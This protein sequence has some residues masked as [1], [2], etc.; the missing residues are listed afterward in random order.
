VQ[1]QV[2]GTVQAEQIEKLTETDNESLDNLMEAFS[3]SVPIKKDDI[4]TGAS[5]VNGRKKSKQERK[6]LEKLKKL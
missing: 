4:S 5:M 6:L 3:A 2:V 1:D